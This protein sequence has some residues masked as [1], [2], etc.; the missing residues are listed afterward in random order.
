MVRVARAAKPVDAVSH[1]WSHRK[2]DDTMTFASAQIGSTRCT[3][4]PLPGLTA[5]EPPLSACP[6]WHANP[7][8]GLPY[9]LPP[10][11]HLSKYFIII[12]TDREMGLACKLPGRLVDDS[13]PFFT[14]LGAQAPDQRPAGDSDRHRAFS[15]WARP[16]VR[17]HDEQRSGGGNGSRTLVVTETR[18]GRSMRAPCLRSCLTDRVNPWLGSRVWS[19]SF[20][21][22]D[23]MPGR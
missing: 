22:S 8:P 1:P 15:H 7:V 23:P 2:V 4:L 14:P 16:A 10:S 17:P 3:P 19:S 11:P 5:L 20:F 13:P 18:L 21:F 9:D 12:P 6:S